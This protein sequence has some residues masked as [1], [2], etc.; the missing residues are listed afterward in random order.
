MFPAV[1]WA[2]AAYLAVS[3]VYFGPIEFWTKPS[4]GTEKLLFSVGAE[5]L[6]WTAFCGALAISLRRPLHLKKVD[7]VLLMLCAA[8]GASAANYLVNGTSIAPSAWVAAIERTG[9]SLLHEEIFSTDFRTGDGELN[10]RAL[11]KTALGTKGGTPGPGGFLIKDILDGHPVCLTNG[12]FGRT[13]VCHDMS[14]VILHTLIP[15]FGLMCACLVPRWRISIFRVLLIGLATLV[16]AVLMVNLLA[17]FELM[18]EHDGFGRSEESKAS[19]GVQN[20]DLLVDA[21]VPQMFLYA[22]MALM[23]A[24]FGLRRRSRR[25]PA[26]P[27]QEQMAS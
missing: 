23:V 10:W 27:A 5:T 3:I 19:D 2:G 13:S 20:F 17:I 15:V 21:A 4:E 25:R 6:R 26:L 7:L 8:I 14:L 24:R 22:F 9:I 12:V 11:A 1:A 16:F 18:I